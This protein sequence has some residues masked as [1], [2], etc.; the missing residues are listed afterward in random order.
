LLNLAFDTAT[1]WGRFALAEG[2]RSVVYRPLNVSGSFADALLP[3]V[4]EMLAEASA[5]LSR[6]GAV[7]V[8]RG[9]GSFT[10]VRIG[11]ATAKGLA[12]GLGVPLVAVPTLAAMAA[13]MLAEAPGRELAVPALDARRGEVFAAV[14]RRGQGWVEPLVEPAARLPEAWWERIQATVDDPEA[15][16]WAGDG[17]ALILGAGSNLR[18]ELRERG[19]PALRSW[20]AAYPATAPA[21]A[22]A[23]GDAAADLDRIHPFALTPLY[24]RTS[25]A[26]VKKKVDLTPRQP[27]TDISFF[28]GEH[29]ESDP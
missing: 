4:A 20:T 1:P 25:D 7:G 17:A 22:R 9:P 3:V 5:D 8:T 15:V 11:V 28:R 26:E 6:I 23:M 19:E 24:L 21:L 16:L 12:F 13:A 27:G 18:P 29:R 14:Y 10:G 2:S